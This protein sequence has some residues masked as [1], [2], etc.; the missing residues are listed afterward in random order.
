M[1]LKL[2]KVA[3]NPERNPFEHMQNHATAQNLRLGRR[4]FY[5]LID[6]SFLKAPLKSF[7]H[8]VAAPNFATKALKKN[9]ENEKK[10]KKYQKTTINH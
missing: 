4:K 1:R 6:L 10:R 8:R 3:L 2:S 7:F 5:E 9:E